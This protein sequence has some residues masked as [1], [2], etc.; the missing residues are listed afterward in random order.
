MENNKFKHGR[1][2]CVAIVFTLLVGLTI[3]LLPCWAFHPCSITKQST[4]VDLPELSGP[5]FARCLMV[6][7]KV[8]Q[9]TA[10]QAVATPKVTTSLPAVTLTHLSF[11]GVSDFM[12]DNT[13]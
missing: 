5:T 13:T 6:V 11:L 2:L 1:K 12:D 9:P 7:T 8:L 4:F 3:Y 10:Q